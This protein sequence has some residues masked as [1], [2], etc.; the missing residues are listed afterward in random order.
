MRYFA[1]LLANAPSALVHW[2]SRV[3]VHRLQFAP[4][5]LLH[6]RVWPGTGCGIVITPAGTAPQRNLPGLLITDGGLVELRIFVGH[7]DHAA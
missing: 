5:M 1:R 2:Y 3:T 4:S 6:W 7:P